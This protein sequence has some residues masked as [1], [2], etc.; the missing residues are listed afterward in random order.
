LE[1]GFFLLLVY[2]LV[3]FITKL[4]LRFLYSANRR[5]EF[6]ADYFAAQHTGP[7]T[8]I[9]SLV[10]LGQRSEAMQILSNE[11]EWLNNLAGEKKPTA[12]FMRGINQRFPRTQL[13]ED[14]AREIAPKIFLEEKLHRLMTAYGLE[15]DQKY[16]DQLIDQAVPALLKKRA[17]YFDTI[18]E[19]NQNILTPTVL[20]D[21]TIDWRVF[22]S[23]DSYF[24]EIEEIKNFIIT[25]LSQPHKMIFEHEILQTPTKDSNHPSFRARILRI[26]EIFYPSEYLEIIQNLENEKIDNHLVG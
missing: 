9:N 25:L 12:N 2:L 13:N 10:H 22:D 23:N 7:D 3:E 1:R 19:D 5:A 6:L 18:T 17:D 26:F 11:I 20:K 14:V 16:T 4:T 8:L 15:F 24:L 21:K